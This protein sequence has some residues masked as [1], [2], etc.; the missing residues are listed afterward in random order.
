MNKPLS[1]CGGP[2]SL[3]PFPDTESRMRC[4]CALADLTGFLTEC[5]KKAQRVDIGPTPPSAAAGFAFPDA[6]GLVQPPS[7]RSAQPIAPCSSS[8]LGNDCSTGVGEPGQHS[9]LDHHLD[10]TS[11]R[12]DFHTTSPAPPAVILTTTTSSPLSINCL[13][14]PIQATVSSS[15][16][17]NTNKYFIT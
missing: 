17:A 3:S 9:C 7:P 11:P 5:G 15:G 13:I 16:C 8:A 4:V 14:V 6:A 10:A 1:P 12:A 2:P